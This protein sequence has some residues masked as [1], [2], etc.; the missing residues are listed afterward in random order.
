MSPR[1]KVRFTTEEDCNDVEPCTSLEEAVDELNEVKTWVTAL[2]W[3]GGVTLP[4][5]MLFMIFVYGESQTGQSKMS[6]ESQ[7]KFATAD[8]QMKG[9]KK[10]IESLDR[11]IDD[12]FDRLE[13]MLPK[14]STP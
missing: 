8:E 7:V 2:K 13:S 3:A 11:K 14:L 1:K 5:A 4:S 12:R 10:D 6:V 9:V